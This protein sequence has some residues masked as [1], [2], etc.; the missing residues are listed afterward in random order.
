MAKRAPPGSADNLPKKPA[1]RQLPTAELPPDDLQAI[2][3]QN[4]RIARLKLGMT[5]QQV[6]DA[7]G[8]AFSYVGKV[9]NGG[10]NVTLDT[11]KK[12]AAVL[13]LDLGQLFRQA[14]SQEEPS[15][16]DG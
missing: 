16:K 4:V 14:P 6:A 2:F 1:P 9:E 12:L 8:M 3:G 13:D 10:K 7:T 11:V 15:S 5:Q